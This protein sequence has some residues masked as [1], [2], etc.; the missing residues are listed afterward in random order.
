MSLEKPALRARLRAERDRFVKANAPEL[1]VPREFADRLAPGKV[2]A[3]Y[4]PLGSETD[5]APLVAAAREAGA[6]LALPHV[7]DKATPM[8]FVRW[9]TGVPLEIGAFG[10]SQPPADAPECDPDIVLTPLLGFDARLDRLGQGAGHYDRAFTRFPDAWRLG[11]AWSAQEIA[12]V[13]TE[14]WDVPLHAILTEKGIRM[15]KEPS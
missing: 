14:I 10:L 6:V 3:A 2:V 12:A 13:P 7:I 4:M 5:P 11:L 1:P 8:R 9:D 15:H